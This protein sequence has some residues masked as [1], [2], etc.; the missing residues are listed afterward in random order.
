METAIQ[1]TFR[2]LIYSMTGMALETIF[3]V[4]GI[5]R[6]SA[7]KI[8]RRVPK[9][10]LEGFVSLYM[11]PLHGLGM[12]FLY[13]WGRGI[14]KEWF[15]LVRFCWWAVVISIM[16]VLW[17][18]FLKKV[19]GFYPWDYY[20]KSKFKVLKNGYTMWTLVPLWGLTGLV[21]EHWSDLLI[22]LSPF[23]SQYFLG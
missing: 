8:D 17:G 2:F 3:A 16:E 10:Y 19:V 14:S 23:V 4:D 21:F 9:K 6:V 12:L 1:W 13:E 22:H 20:A 11:I 7:V 18:V 15:W 5:E